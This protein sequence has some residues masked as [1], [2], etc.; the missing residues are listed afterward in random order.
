MRRMVALLIVVM[1]AAPAVAAPVQLDI[2]GGFTM[3]CIV[4]PLEMQAAYQYDASYDPGK[5]VWELQGK[6][7]GGGMPYS[8]TLN[9]SLPA[10]STEAGFGQPWSISGTTGHPV[11]VADG[12]GLPESGVVTGADRTYHMAGTVGNATLGG[13]WT[14]VA[15]PSVASQGGAMPVKAN[16]VVAGAH[17]TIT[18]W[19]IT[20]AIAVL[21]VAQRGRYTDI[22]FVMSALGGSDRAKHM[23]LYVLYGDGTDE[24]LIWSGTDDD[25]GSGPQTRDIELGIDI[26]GWQSVVHFS[27]SYNLTTGE[28]GAIRKDYNGGDL[29]EFSTPVVLDDSKDLYGIKIVDSDPGDKYDY[30]GLAIYAATAV[31]EPATMA[32]LGLGLVG[33][34]ARRR[35]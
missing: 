10:A 2:S 24:Q 14:E 34:V 3:D 23:D 35:R 7:P 4:G 21:P 31:P 6:E 28:T 19:Q 25:G 8:H 22:N 13:D 9:R 1:L 17:S 20:E 27:A 16:A 18:T 12:E 11:W 33:L 15:D 32:L 5:D 26:T 29:Y 30:R